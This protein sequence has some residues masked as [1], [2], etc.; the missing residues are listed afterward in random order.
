MVFYELV[1]GR[2]PFEG[3]YDEV[4]NQIINFDQVP[5]SDVNSKAMPVE[6]IITRCL[7]KEKEERYQSMIELMEDVK[8]FVAESKITEN[9]V[10]RIYDKTVTWKQT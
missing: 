9:S 1:T 2:F 5:P 6:H 8:K 4:V 7:K 3:D 10:S